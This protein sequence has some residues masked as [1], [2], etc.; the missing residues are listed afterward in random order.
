MTTAVDPD[1]RL[2]AA[3]KLQNKMMEDLPYFPLWYWS[4]ALVIRKDRDPGV[5][6]SQ[7]SLSG[8]YEPLMRALASASG[9][10]K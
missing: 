5:Q 3:G 8:A 4:N 1:A 2:R 10:G 6:S 7:L 9:A